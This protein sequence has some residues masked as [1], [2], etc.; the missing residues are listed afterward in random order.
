MSD[1]TERLIGIF[2]D[3]FWPLLQAGLEYTVPLTLVSYAIGLV[4]ALVTAISRISRWGPLSMVF[5]FYVWLIRGTP[6]IVQL[7]VIFYGLPS[8]GV[9]LDPFTAAVIGFS[10]SV[11]AYGSEIVRAAI[12][13]IPDG[14]WEAAYASGMRRSQVLRWVVIPQAVNVSVPPMFNAF[15]SLVKDTSLAATITV[16]ELFRKSQQITAFTYEPLLMYC[17]VALI[18]LIFS[19]L[20]TI[21]QDRLERRFSRQ[22]ARIG[23]AD[24]NR[25]S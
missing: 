16:T 14:Q 18:Y 24:G 11:G 5:R 21:L 2:T 10:L 6:L 22:G 20:L 23:E 15:I 25:L 8:I 4:L 12:L 1:R 9:T 3:S 17:E 7:F 13:S 19:T